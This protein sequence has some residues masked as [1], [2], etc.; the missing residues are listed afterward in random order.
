MYYDRHTSRFVRLLA[1]YMKMVIM[2]SISSIVSDRSSI[3]AIL[4][5]ISMGE[6]AMVII[7]IMKAELAG[8]FV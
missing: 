3:S 1:L 7:K 2:L 6:V 4:I 5:T 8:G